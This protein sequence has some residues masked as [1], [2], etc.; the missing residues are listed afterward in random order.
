LTL[1]LKNSSQ[2][3]KAYHAPY[4]EGDGGGYIWAVTEEGRGVIKR[5]FIIAPL[6]FDWEINNNNY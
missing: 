5:W 2:I 3:F 4:I 1:I 6:Y